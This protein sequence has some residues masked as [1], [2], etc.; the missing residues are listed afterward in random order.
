MMIRD[1]TDA[2]ADRTAKD[3]KALLEVLSRSRPWRRPVWFMR[4][5][6]R[7]LPEYQEVRRRAGS[8]LELCDAPELACEVTLQPLRR[9]DLDA[10]IVFADILLVPRALGSDLD[11]REG[12][13]PVLSRIA[14]ERD[15][16]RL[17][18]DG[19]T[20]R[21]AAVYETVRRVR[22]ELA[23]HVAL[24]GFCGAPWT[25]ASYMIEGGTSGDRGLAR[26]AAYERQ[27]WFD[28]L[29]ELLTETA[30]DHL[31]RQIEAGADVVQVFDSWAGDLDDGL[32]QRYSEAPIRRIVEGLAARGHE[33]PVIGFARGVGAGHRASWRR[34]A[35]RPHRWN[36]RCRSSGWPP[37]SRRSCR[38][39]A[40]SIRWRWRSAGPRC[41]AESSTWC[42][43]C[44]R[45]GT[46]STSATGCGPT[47]RRPMWPRR[48]ISSGR[49]TGHERRALP[50]DQGPARRGG[51]LLDGRAALSAAAVRLSLRRRGRQCGIGDLQGDGA[52][53]DGG[54][55]D[56]GDA[57]VM[58]AR[59]WPDRR[60][61][62]RGVSRWLLAHGQGRP[63]DRAHRPRTC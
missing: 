11:F 48:W 34:P 51:D 21:L 24:I 38:C 33:T 5:A 43:P 18:R 36:G 6:G 1:S 46:S 47:R 58:G 9:F 25:V 41:G 7:Y 8:F 59:A 2:P 14:S 53:A 40:T 55:H 37:S 27:P 22:A 56:A 28:A 44:R 32:R 63:G 60:A 16:A 49:W 57:G 23:S 12:E 3:R 15:V 54:H 35:W 13:G 39:R 62:A 31:A 26:R 17:S 42:A 10:A 52:A 19:M 61:R 29:I 30:C 50:V 45:T 4:Q 20:D